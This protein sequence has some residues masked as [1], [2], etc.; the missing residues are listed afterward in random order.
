M[1]VLLRALLLWGVHA[2]TGTD[3]ESMIQSSLSAQGSQAKRAS[4]GTT[5][6]SEAA[7]QEMKRLNMTEA[8]MSKAVTST[9]AAVRGQASTRAA[10][11][12]LLRDVRQALGERERRLKKA[13]EKFL[14]SANASGMKS[15]PQEL[16]EK[17]KAAL[18]Q[19]H[20]MSE[21][22]DVVRE[23]SQSLAEKPADKLLGNFD[24]LMVGVGTTLAPWNYF[25]LELDLRLTKTQWRVFLNFKVDEPWV[26]RLCFGVATA[27]DTKYGSLEHKMLNG[28]ELLAGASKW[29]NIPGWSFGVGDV[30]DPFT[31]PMIS[32]FGWKWTSTGDLPE[33]VCLF[34]DICV[35]NADDV[36]PSA[37]ASALQTEMQVGVAEELGNQQLPSPHRIQ[38][39]EQTW[40][41]PTFDMR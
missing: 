34:F 30:V 5:S 20:A 16:L 25:L 6:F 41:T 33:P 13:W 3:V 1:A 8:A 4:S 7:S 14:H 31:V 35:L 11:G 21:M 37:S 38:F 39:T 22:Q 9:L 15:T 29:E 28:I 27:T 2:V 18:T 24:S 19:T 23:V 17:A 36:H 26:K 12:N 10:A 40:C 32:D